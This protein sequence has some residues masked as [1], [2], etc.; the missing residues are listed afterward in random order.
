L[1]DAPL[2]VRAIR[3]E[4][5]NAWLPLWDGY[6]AFYERAGATALGEDITHA[7]FARFLDPHEPVHALVAEAGA[8][9]VGLA[10]YLFHRSTLQ[11]ADV[12]YLQ[13]LF[14]DPAARGRGIGEALLRAVRA[15]A[16][17]RGAARVYWHTQ[18]SNATARKLYDR[19]AEPSGF[20]VYRL[21]T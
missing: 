11:R 17:A 6:N 18:A 19:F 16:K 2:V 4:D 3:A 1:T 20:I 5:F 14:T 12:C 13:D 9:L 8:S 15:E 10:H 7:T 21:A